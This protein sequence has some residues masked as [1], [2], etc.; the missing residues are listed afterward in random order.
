MCC[1]LSYLIK[2]FFPGRWSV[3]P[4]P[5]SPSNYSY[6]RSDSRSRSP[7]HRVRSPRRSSPPLKRT[8]SRSPQPRYARRRYS[9]GCRT[10]SRSPPLLPQASNR[11]NAHSRGR[12]RS[13]LQPRRNSPALNRNGP[14]S[15]R[16]HSPVATQPPHSTS[17]S[18][19]SNSGGHQRKSP[20]PRNDYQ[21]RRRTRSPPAG[22]LDGRKRSHSRSPG[23]GKYGRD[24]VPA[25]KKRKTPPANTLSSTSSSNRNKPLRD[26][27]SGLSANDQA[28]KHSRSGRER[29]PAAHHHHRR[30]TRSRSRHRN[31][32]P[33]KLDA[34]S[35]PIDNNNRRNDSSETSGGNHAQVQ[36]Q[37]PTTTT[38]DAKTSMPDDKTIHEKPTKEMDVDSRPATS[39]ENDD[40]DDGDDDDGIDLFA[41]EESES[42][43]EG[44][45]K[46]GSSK[47]ERPSNASTLSFSKLGTTNASAVVRD[48]NEVS[49][50]YKQLPAIGSGGNSRKGRGEDRHRNGR[51]SNYRRNRYGAG[52][53]SDRKSPSRERSRARGSW[54]SESSRKDGGN[55][56]DGNDKS[57]KHSSKVASKVTTSD[58]RK[59]T[60]EGKV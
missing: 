54:K 27:D 47:T 37:Q 50:D 24:A 22:R 55:N 1:C 16:G 5:H 30:R 32:N 7:V 14:K 20:S 45:F 56:R 59:K 2:I 41:S 42:E 34:S 18:N 17:R 19:G 38:A 31:P 53:N 9:P 36:Q 51:D 6:R 10:K 44:R 25:N 23:R 33:T 48:L 8:Q 12:T 26:R 60:S 57:K 58:S 28:P 35:G 29:S 15:Y 13:P 39:D 4:P 46:S 52:N 11:G 49:S 40:S 43:N 3:T 21:P